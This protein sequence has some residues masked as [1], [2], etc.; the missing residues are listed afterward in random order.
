[1]KKFYTYD[2]ETFRYKGIV[3]VNDSLENW[4]IYVP[5]YSVSF[6]PLEL[7]DNTIE[8]YYDAPGN[9][10]ANKTKLISADTPLELAKKYKIGELFKE[11]EAQF[12]LVNEKY[13]A[14]EREGWVLQFEEAK[15]FLRTQDPTKAPTL[16]LMI[17]IRGRNETLEEFATSIVE[18]NNQFRQLY[19]AVTA[20]QQRMYNDIISLEIVEDVL[21]YKI[22]FMQL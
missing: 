19:A 1:M 9:V 14:T 4:G 7:T 18:N 17:Y 10:W 5:D 20:Q 13:S 12:N 2:H 16:S 21:D 3:E 11:Y 8:S 6:A 22:Q 15:E